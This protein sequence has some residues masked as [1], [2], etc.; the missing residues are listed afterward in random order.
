MDP[1]IR[2]NSQRQS[3]R[4]PLLIMANQQFVYT[5]PQRKSMCM[6]IRLLEEA[7]ENLWVKEKNQKEK[8]NILL[9]FE[10]MTIKRPY[11]KTCLLQLKS[12]Q[13][14]IFSIKDVYQKRKEA[15]HL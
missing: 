12:C 10:L 2:K 4:M 13:R 14:D 6:Y 9:Y 7:G 8:Q 3:Q 11:I 5:H 1:Q 15:E